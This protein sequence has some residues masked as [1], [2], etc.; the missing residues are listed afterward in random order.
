MLDYVILTRKT[1]YFK[2]PEGRSNTLRN[3]KE[4]LCRKQLATSLGPFGSCFFLGVPTRNILKSFPIFR[5]LV[6]KYRNIGVRCLF[7]S[8]ITS[9]CQI[10]NAI[11]CVV[12]EVS[13]RHIILSMKMWFWNA[14]R[15]VSAPTPSTGVTLVA[16]TPTGRTNKKFSRRHLTRGSL[17]SS[18]S[19]GSLTQFQAY[20]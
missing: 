4:D 3:P 12:N 19:N 11:F 5:G 9:L 13:Q 2:K 18:L 10:L 15:L 7:P 8:M 1:R 16:S 17:S 14:L 6:R 20:R